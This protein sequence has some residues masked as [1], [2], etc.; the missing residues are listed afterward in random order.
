MLVVALINRPRQFLQIIHCVR[1]GKKVPQQVLGSLG[2]FDELKANGR[3]MV[4]VATG[5]NYKRRC[6]KW[7]QLMPR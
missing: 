7:K 2:R 3:L 5:I 4:C 1:E 6:S